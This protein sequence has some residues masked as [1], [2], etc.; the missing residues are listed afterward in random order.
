MFS[1]FNKTN[2]KDAIGIDIGPS[3]VKVVQLRK[4]DER[5]VLVTYGE[6]ELGPYAGLAPS[7][8]AILGEDKMTEVIKDLLKETKVTCKE[9][10]MAVDSSAAYVSTITVPKLP[11]NEEKFMIPIEARKYIPIPISDVKL[12]W[13]QIPSK[14][15]NDRTKE[16]VLVAVKNETLES[17]ARIAKN[18]G[19][20]NLE[21]EIEGFSLVR[22]LLNNNQ[23]FFIFVDL[24]S[25]YTTV[26]VIKDGVVIDMNIINHG[27]QEGTV[28]LSKSLSLTVETAEETK[29]TFGYVGDSSNEYVKEILKL[30]SYPLFGELARLLLMYER[31]YNQVIEGVVLS[32]GGA[33][34]AGVL[35]VYKDTVHSDAVIATPFDKIVYPD[36]LKNIISKVGPTYSVAVGLALKKLL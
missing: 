12:D 8:V 25:I 10:V 14:E 7:Q 9:A 24:G 32:G 19:F 16:I 15:E 11:P 4:E 6:I 13:W 36:F 2:K 22:S 33:K 3:S 1:I 26:N 17:Y 27:S 5:I 28:Q 34:V 20:V 21:V 18:L 30:S 31:K 29:R 35:D 23:G